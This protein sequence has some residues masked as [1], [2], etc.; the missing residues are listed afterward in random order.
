MKPKRNLPSHIILSTS[1]GY[2]SPIS[3]S[4]EHQAYITTQ[5]HFPA[6]MDKTS[7]QQCT[8]TI[9]GS[10]AAVL[11][12]DDKLELR[13]TEE[14]GTYSLLSSATA[15]RDKPSDKQ[16][17]ENY[18]P[19]YS[20]FELNIKA[21]F[22]TEDQLPLKIQVWPENLSPEDIKLMSSQAGE[23]FKSAN[24]PVYAAWITDA[25]KG[26][27][28]H[29]SLRH[30]WKKIIARP[31][32][33]TSRRHS[34]FVAGKM[35]PRPRNLI[36]A[37]VGRPSLATLPTSANHWNSLE[38]ERLLYLLHTYLDQLKKNKSTFEN[39]LQDSGL[40][41]HDQVPNHFEDSGS[42]RLDEKLIRWESAEEK[43]RRDY[44]SDYL[45]AKEN[46]TR[47]PERWQIGFNEIEGVMDEVLQWISFLSRK[48][49][50][51]QNSST[52]QG[53]KYW[54]HQGYSRFEK[55]ILKME[56]QQS[57]NT[58][59][60]TPESFQKI[61]KAGIR[62]TQE[63]FEIWCFIKL[64]HGIQTH[65]GLTPR[66]LL[67][68]MFEY[69]K[70]V[71]KLRKTNHKNH[72]ISMRFESSTG[73]TTIDLF[74]EPTLHLDESRNYFNV[75]GKQITR[76]KCAPDML[77]GLSQTTPRGKKTRWIIIDAK[78]FDL[79]S[80]D[81]PD[82]SQS[83][84]YHDKLRELFHTLYKYDE[85]S[86]CGLTLDRGKS[87]ETRIDD[88]AGIF[89]LF[90]KSTENSSC[91]EAED[92]CTR[93]EIPNDWALPG[94][95][96]FEDFAHLIEQ[97][98]RMERAREKACQQESRQDS[99]SPNHSM[100][101]FPC[102][103]EEGDFQLQRLLWMIQI[104]S[105]ED[106]VYACPSCSTKIDRLYIIR[107]SEFNDENHFINAKAKAERDGYAY[108][109]YHCENC[110][111]SWIRNHC[112][113]A[114]AK[115]SIFKFTGEL[116][117]LNFHH[118]TEHGDWPNPGHYRCPNCNDDYSKHDFDTHYG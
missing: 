73:N 96:P 29:D 55:E 92:H 19:Q 69:K 86:E 115:H 30:A 79:S 66:G 93:W 2:S 32:N 50:V 3:F 52:I 100:G 80:L 20:A 26:I 103:L 94:G 97:G 98:S 118:P 78:Y 23:I 87:G 110:F 34:R 57:L 99:D 21:Q 82:K 16:I 101:I 51:E 37:R 72:S 28:Q 10:S 39:L 8:I 102:D 107:D 49:V 31:L 5:Y 74:P 58:S 9:P 81:N 48:G 27:A 47:G 111:L 77:L 53:L 88:V 109:H 18:L 65:C 42:R 105:D 22:E 108:W 60:L 12:G 68:D 46:S 70:G 95:L 6:W 14:V 44:A 67:K 83:K 91:P 41:D 43:W 36:A 15:G 75:G 38:N 62:P 90:S 54:D 117:H 106:E 84:S 11:V 112:R 113:S 64:V 104:W 76:T 114:D 35:F 7:F 17:K 25:K 13:H 59:P 61:F 56:R 116:S 1:N 85:D 33:T 40:T 24:S 45:T 63:I 4:E 71:W 89:I